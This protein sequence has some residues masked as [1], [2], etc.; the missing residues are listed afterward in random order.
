MA[1]INNSRAII[2]LDGVVDSL[3]GGTTNPQGVLRIYSG[4]PPTNVDTGL[5]GNTILS[6]HDLSNPAFGNATDNNPN[7]IATAGAVADDTSANAT[8]TATFARL[9]DRDDVAR[10]QLT[11]SATG[12]G[13]EV[14]INSTSI[15]TSTLVQVT[16]MTMTMPEG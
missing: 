1:S 13:G 9:F 8:G 16:S 5:S 2:I 11:V 3:D 6:E 10:V 15:V 4:T 12:G 14:Q 7:A